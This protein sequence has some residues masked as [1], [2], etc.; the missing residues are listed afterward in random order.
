MFRAQKEWL[1][2][3]L[4]SSETCQ[5]LT[6]KLEANSRWGISTWTHGANLILVSFWGCLRLG[7]HR[8]G[9]M[10]V[11][12]RVTLFSTQGLTLEGVFLEILK[13][14]LLKNTLVLLSCLCRKKLNATH[15]RK[16]KVIYSAL[17]IARVLATITFIWQRLKGRQG[18]ERALQWAKGMVSGVPLLEAIGLGKPRV[19]N[20]EHRSLSDWLGP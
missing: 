18:S 4:R 2:E 13:A 14:R 5:R 11:T 16:A 19:A 7:G 9:W 3:G 15:M 10:T 12:V 1:Q 6:E 17:A 20:L 8:K